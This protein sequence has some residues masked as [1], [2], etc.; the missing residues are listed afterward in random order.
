[1]GRHRKPRTGQRI[2]LVVSAAAVVAA[3][4][5]LVYG[6]YSSIHPVTSAVP[7][8]DAASASA[9]RSV[10]SVATGPLSG[11]ASSGANAPA[12]PVAAVTG[13]GEV[14]AEQVAFGHTSV[15]VSARTPA[16]AG[17]PS[18]SRQDGLPPAPPRSPALTEPSDPG[19]QGV[20]LPCLLGR[21]VGSVLD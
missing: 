15:I 14:R 18:R 12:F 3:A 2:P 16:S 8:R 9:S 1:M 7:A 4:L 19:G 21:V 6:P 5:G 10:E 20:C 17:G 11:T 13:P